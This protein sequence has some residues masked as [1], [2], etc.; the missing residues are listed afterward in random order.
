MGC[1]PLRDQK[2]RKDHK[3]IFDETGHRSA[4][5]ALHYSFN[6][7][8]LSPP[9]TDKSI[10]NLGA[11]TIDPGQRLTDFGS[12]KGRRETWFSDIG[13]WRAEWPAWSGGETVLESGRRAES[14]SC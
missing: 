4:L 14:S 11:H 5:R 9:R 12:S 13:K 2:G 10:I 6:K 7:F 3:G 8:L 1:D